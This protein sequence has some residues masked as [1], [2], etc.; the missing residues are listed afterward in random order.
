MTTETQTLL[1]TIDTDIE[2]EA[3]FDAIGAKVGGGWRVIQAIPVSGGEMGSEGVSESF[4][5][6]QVTVERE[7]DADN[8]VVGADRGKAARLADSAATALFDEDATTD[9]V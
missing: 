6:F 3:R 5:R 1:V 4:A 9:D 2:Q 8:V 7:I